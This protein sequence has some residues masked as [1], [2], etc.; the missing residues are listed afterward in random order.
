V[1]IL[2]GRSENLEGWHVNPRYDVYMPTKGMVERLASSYDIKPTPV[3]K[4][5]AGNYSLYSGARL[6]A[7]MAL[8][9]KGSYVRVDK[10]S[11]EEVYIADLDHHVSLN[12]DL[13]EL[14]EAA[15]VGYLS[16]FDADY[17]VVP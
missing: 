5:L 11:S 16:S 4:K 8:S 3:L 17:A 15:S 9:E 1:Y 12:K 14:L 13:L 6:I 10:R 2:S 7:D